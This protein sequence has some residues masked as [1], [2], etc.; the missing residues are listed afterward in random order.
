MAVS[1]LSMT[2]D[3]AT[4]AEGVTTYKRDDVERRYATLKTQMEND[5]Q[6][7]PLLER[8]LSE[9]RQRVE[10]NQYTLELFEALVSAFDRDYPKYPEEEKKESV[11]QPMKPVV[12][13]ETSKEEKVDSEKT[14]SVNISELPEDDEIDK[15]K[16]EDKV[17][18]VPKE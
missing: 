7:I 17:D 5:L 9:A 12:T 4:V 13:M 1:L 10:A 14:S 15:E 16:E 18:E 3:E 2:K 6:R 11:K 8:E